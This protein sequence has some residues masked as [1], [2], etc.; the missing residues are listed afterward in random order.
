MN[1]QEKSNSV[2]ELM[3]S[4]QDLHVRQPLTITK[5]GRLVQDLRHEIALLR[6]VISDLGGDPNIKFK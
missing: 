1:Q 4:M 6:G 3:K 5:L 2:I